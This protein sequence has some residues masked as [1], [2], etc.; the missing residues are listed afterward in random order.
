[1]QEIGS[2]PRAHSVHPQLLVKIAVQ[3]K[4]HLDEAVHSDFT[5]DFGSP[6]SLIALW[7]R[8]LIW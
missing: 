4:G 8:V 2:S 6:E 5:T 7:A 3:I 1:M